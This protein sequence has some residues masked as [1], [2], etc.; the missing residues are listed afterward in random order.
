MQCRVELQAFRST[1]SDPPTRVWMR[2]LALKRSDLRDELSRFHLHQS[3]HMPQLGQVPD[4]DSYSTQIDE[5]YGRPEE[6]ALSLPSDWP[7]KED[8][9]GYGWAALAEREYILRRGAADDALSKLKLSI[10]AYNALLTK[11]HRDVRGQNQVTRFEQKV[12]TQHKEIK[13]HAEAYRR[14]FRALDRLGISE[15]DSVRYQPLDDKDLQHL[16]ISADKPQKL[17]ESHIA[18]PWFWGGDRDPDGIQADGVSLDA[19]TQEG[20]HL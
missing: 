20:T 10:Q 3:I 7:D 5:D 19:L 9:H 14:H 8:R 12:K 1:A 18:Q 4:T 15:E 11:G 17:G 16:H 13:R 2:E 6:E